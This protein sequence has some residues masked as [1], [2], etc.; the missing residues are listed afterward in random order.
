MPRDE[1]II[2][3]T[4]ALTVVPR[5]EVSP[6]IPQYYTIQRRGNRVRFQE[7]VPVKVQFWDAHLVDISCSGALVQHTDRIRPGEVYRLSFPG[8]VRKV[9]VLV[10]AVRSFVSEVVRITRGEG[11]IVYRSGM[12]F[13]DGESRVAELVTGSIDRILREKPGL[14]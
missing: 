13:V 8:E 4:S 14:Q 7:L 11:Q 1:L 3:S 2:D 10:R 6:G 5:A 9:Q 12:E